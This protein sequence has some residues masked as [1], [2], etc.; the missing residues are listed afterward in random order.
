M[1]IMFPCK[2]EKKFLIQIISCRIRSSMHY[3]GIKINK[4]L[5]KWCPKRYITSDVVHVDLTNMGKFYV[6]NVNESRDVAPCGGLC[7]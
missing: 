3:V 2:R 4:I 6:G 1:H 7:P 5:Y